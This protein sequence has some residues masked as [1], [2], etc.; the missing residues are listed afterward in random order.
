MH[1]KCIYFIMMNLAKSKSQKKKKKMEI[2]L[3]EQV[4]LMKFR[5][6]HGIVR[7]VIVNYFN[8]LDSLKNYLKDP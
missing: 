4:M 1:N 7:L 2:L 3:V 6:L 5:L 8:P